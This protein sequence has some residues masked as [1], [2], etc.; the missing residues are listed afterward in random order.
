MVKGS[1]WDAEIRDQKG[2]DEEM[3]W[4]WWWLGGGVGGRFSEAERWRSV[5]APD[6]GYQQLT[7]S[8]KQPVARKRPQVA[9]FY[10]SV[11]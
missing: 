5:T 1:G 4:L 3:C 2:A 9:L 7:H 6:S 11:G 8:A 10:T